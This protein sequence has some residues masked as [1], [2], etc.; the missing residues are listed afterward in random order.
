MDLTKFVP[1]RMQTSKEMVRQ[2]AN[3]FFTLFLVQVF[4]LDLTKFGLTPAIDWKVSFLLYL[5]FMGPLTWISNHQEIEKRN[6][7]G[8]GETP[9]APPPELPSA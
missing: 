5:I 3:A 4:G 2:G 6:G 1:E 9:S 7:T 8:T